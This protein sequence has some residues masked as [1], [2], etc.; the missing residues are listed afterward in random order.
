MKKLSF[1]L[2]RTCQALVIATVLSAF[3]L[4]GDVCAVEAICPGGASPN[5]SVVFCEDFD[6]GSIM[7]GSPHWWDVGN[8]HDHGMAD[9]VTC[10]GNAYGGGT[11]YGGGC[12]F[13]S[14]YLGRAEGAQLDGQFAWGDKTTPWF[15]E[16][17][18]YVRYYFKKSAGQ[19][20]SW[21]QKGLLV[22]GGGPG[23]QV[24][25]D[26]LCAEKFA[27]HS[28][29]L[30]QNMGME[31]AEQNIGY[32]LVAQAD[33]WYLV[34]LHVKMNTPGSADGIAEL[35]MDDATTGP[36]SSQTLRMRYTNLNWG[37]TSGSRWKRVSLLTNYQNSATAPLYQY[38]WYDQ[39]VVSKSRIGPMGA[40][41]SDISPPYTDTFSPS[42]GATGVAVGATS[43]SFHLKDTGTISSGADS[44]SLTVNCPSYGG[45]KTCAAGLTCTGSSADYTV[46]YGSLSL[47]YSNV[48]SCTINGQDLA[49]PPNVMSQQNYSFTVQPN[50]N[51]ALSVTT[52]SLPGGT[53]GTAYSQTLSATGGT[54]PYTWDISAG[55]LPSGLSISS[56]GIISGT[57]TTSQTA[58]FTART[59]DAVS[60]TATKALS[61]SIVPGGGGGGTAQNTN[62][63][64]TYITIGYPTT[65]YGTDNTLE[66]Y[67]WPYATQASRPIIFDNIDIQSLPNNITITS[68]TLRLYM[69]GYFGNGGTNPM[70]IYA[71]RISGTLPN[72]TN[73]T[74][75]NFA[76]TLTELGYTDVNLTSG[77][78]E[79]LVTSAVQSAYA[80]RQPVYILLDGKNLGSQ[81]TNRLFA[82]MDHPTTAWRP[83]LSVTYTEPQ[84]I[85]PPVAPTGHSVSAGNAQATLYRGTST[86]ATAYNCYWTSNGS[87]PSK[88]N[89]TKIAGIANAYILTGLTNN[90]A[91]KFVFTATNQ[92]GES[93]VS[94]TDIATPISP[95]D[96]AVVPNPPTLHSVGAGNGYLNL[97]PGTSSG[98]SSYNAY[99]TTDLSSPTTGST[100]ITGATGGQRLTATNGLTYKFVFTAVN[101]TGESTVSTVD[102]ATPTANEAVNFLTN[103]GNYIT[104]IINGLKNYLQ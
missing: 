91:Y 59:T 36:P 2:I 32:D 12:A 37:A 49:S 75:N 53:I 96:P 95:P 100:K 71:Y 94:S 27:I 74:W 44:S 26:F 99:Y 77:F 86:G 45:S 40:S 89:G 23:A 80:A 15:S 104:T 83:Q 98:A 41:T 69:Y 47:G 7:D 39:V 48:V 1:L 67:Q 11:G 102:T 51:P 14:D 62:F 90:V 61:I 5:S 35:W 52:A 57:P 43:F 34:E 38:V 29:E 50:P 54:S 84:N 18:V 31:F 81:D 3:L 66:V 17:E 78:K 4:A 79:W 70:S 55:S 42:N 93:V 25:S 58:S 60:S 6:D 68:A 21:A 103:T 28:Y 65:N 85:L 72:T 9:S 97:F 87:T 88:T 10:A 92:Y 33:K 64:D 24:S 76:G 22:D 30:E 82:S 13:W 56:R 19:C 20:A 16:T 8:Y 63:A 73:V 46:T 101:V